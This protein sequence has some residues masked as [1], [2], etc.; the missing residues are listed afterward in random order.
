MVM[1]EERKRKITLC[2]TKKER[3]M[4][5]VFSLF[6]LLFLPILTNAETV[7]IDGIWYEL[8]TK[9][10]VAEVSSANGYKYKGDVIIPE[11][12]T[13]NG[14]KYNVTN[15]RNSTFYNCKELTSISIPKSVKTIGLNAFFGCT[16]LTTVYITDLNAWCK[17]TFGDRNSN[18][19]AFANYLY[20]NG[21]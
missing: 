21:I 10:K 14:I 8:V 17:I 13:Y 18:P 9:G 15:I 20:L 19:L 1:R 4:K 12:V 11:T 3:I 16:N 7:E 5:K 6:L 2:I